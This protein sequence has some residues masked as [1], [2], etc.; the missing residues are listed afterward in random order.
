MQYDET[1]RYRQTC[2]GAKAGCVLTVK[3][4]HCGLVNFGDSETCRRC[5]QILPAPWE[6]ASA[7]AAS[8]SSP[9]RPRRAGR[10]TSGGAKVA[11]FL[12]AAAGV[13]A[14]AAHSAGGDLAHG[15][16]IGLI[17]L[18]VL[19]IFVGALLLW[20]AAFQE[21]IAWGL[22]C[23]LPFGGLIFLVTHWDAGKVPLTFQGVGVLFLLFGALGGAA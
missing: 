7:P 23:L 6:A 14:F 8:T 4:P 11:L 13:A 20:V 5:R 10:S 12:I 22:L 3:C 21:G 2:S 17:A 9:R 18:G 1:G 16:S 15:T 19:A